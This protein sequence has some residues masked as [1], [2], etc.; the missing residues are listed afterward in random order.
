MRGRELGKQTYSPPDD[1]CSLIRLHDF[2]AESV[3][4]LYLDEGHPGPSIGNQST[5]TP[6][7]GALEL[8][9]RG[10]RGKLHGWRFG[11]SAVILLRQAIRGR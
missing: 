8:C 5:S 1:E 4:A 3:P 7:L 2:A 10:A 11:L 9:N 6:Q